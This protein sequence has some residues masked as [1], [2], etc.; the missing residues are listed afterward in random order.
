MAV[1]ATHLDF[2]TKGKKTTTAAKLRMFQDDQMGG[3]D[4]NDARIAW[5]RGFAEELVIR[6]GQYWERLLEDRSRGWFIALDVWYARLPERGQKAADFG[7]TIGIAPETQTIG[8]WLVSDPLQ[9][10]WN[11]MDPEDLKTAAEDWGRRILGGGSG[12]THGT[13]DHNFALLDDPQ[14][15]GGA[16]PIRYTTAVEVPPVL[17]VIDRNPMLVD[18]P[19]GTRMYNHAS[20][21]ADATSSKSVQI[22]SPFGTVIGTVPARA[23]YRTLDGVFQLVL[24]R[25]ADLQNM[26]TVKTA[27]VDTDKLLNDRDAQW[28]AR[29][30][31]PR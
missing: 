16:V 22:P 11:W 1:L 2:H 27:T 14:D 30:T 28:I 21:P 6:D 19:I 17:K 3:T 10:G 24:I 25:T 9:D 29:L 4:S 23:V 12:K 20:Q 7:H 31:P 18:V 13:G 8:Q 15:T 26:T 5:E